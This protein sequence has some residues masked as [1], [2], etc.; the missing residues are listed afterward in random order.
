MLAWVHQA[1]ASEKEFL[2]SLF[3]GSGDVTVKRMVGSEWLKAKEK[4]GDI[5]P[6]SEEA[7]WVRELMDRNLEKLCAPLR[8]SDKNDLDP[9]SN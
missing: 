2:D 1:M 8:V 5:L 6:E 9:D 7:S 3:P 4:D